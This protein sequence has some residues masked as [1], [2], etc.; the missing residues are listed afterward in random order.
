VLTSRATASSGEAVAI[1]FK[2][3]P[4]TRSF[5]IPTRGLSTS[6]AVFRL[7]DGA[8]MFLTVATMADRTGRLYGSAVD[9][10]E[11]TEDVQLA[12]TAGAPVDASIS[13]LLL[14]WR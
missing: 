5:G 13:W 8:T 2:G 1:S 4:R 10:D 9:V 12:P 14:S 7:R 6:N 3:R 11:E